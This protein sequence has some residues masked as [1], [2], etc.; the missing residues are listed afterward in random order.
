MR[1]GGILFF[2]G[3][4]VTQQPFYMWLL[5]GQTPMD[6][7]LI[8]C[9]CLMSTMTKV[10]CNTNSAVRKHAY[11]AKKVNLLFSYRIDFYIWPLELEADFDES[12]IFFPGLNQ[13][14][15]QN[16]LLIACIK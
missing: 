16:A 11:I 5:I 6:Q 12:Y 15:L 8:F 2:L 4:M 10:S 9:I 14:L 1:A 3:C 7:T 13:H